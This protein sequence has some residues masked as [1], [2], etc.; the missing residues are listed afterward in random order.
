MKDDLSLAFGDP[1]ARAFEGRDGTPKDRI[2]L[3][4][5]VL[6][7]EIGA[8][9]SE[10]GNTQRVRFDAVVEVET[11]A[12]ALGDDVD[13]V[14][15][16]D[17][18]VE[19]IEVELAAERLNL[20]E[21]LAERIADRILL[22]PRTSRV[23]LRTEKLDRGPFALGVEIERSRTGEIEKAHAVAPP[24]PRVVFLTDKAM[25]SPNLSKMLDYLE[26][27]D[28]PLVLCVDALSRGPQAA[29][30]A[31]Q[32][33]IDLLSI[34]QSAWVLAGRDKRCLVVD[35][36][37]EI[38]WALRNRRTIVWAP[39]RM[40]LDAL[41]E[42]PS[43]DDGPVGLAAWIAGQLSAT[44]FVVLGRGSAPLPE[45]ARQLELDWDGQL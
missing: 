14:V 13:Q 7:I 41:S 44:D 35:A 45:G 6:E 1:H 21:T 33:R 34:E 20:L 17:L 37:T 31:A 42:A 3:R 24:S 32:R 10:R 19:A 12:G 27:G 28:A 23:F 15:S 43:A 36:R 26:A 5:Y 39:G 11:D 29:I 2:S 9:Q 30:A 25:S 4:D 22:H 40:V 18:I 16:Y 8:F 38:D